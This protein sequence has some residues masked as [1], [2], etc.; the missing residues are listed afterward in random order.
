[1]E[2]NYRKSN[3]N[4]LFSNFVDK[5]LLNVDN[6]QNY[7]PLYSRFFDLNLTNFNSIN[8]NHSQS[9]S[10]IT[11]KKSENKFL[12]K[13]KNE[14]DK[15]F[16]TKPIFFK[17]S[18]L[19]DP[20]KFLIG[21]YHNQKSLL[22]LPKL[23]SS[24]CH[25]KYLDT[26]N[27]SY[28]DGFFT[29]LTSMLLHKHNFSHGVDFY[30]SYLAIKNDYKFNIFDD[31]EYLQDSKYFKANN[32]KE[33]DDITFSLDNEYISDFISTGSNCNRE[34]L[35]LNDLDDDDC[36]LTLSDIS[37]L[38]MLDSIFKPKDDCS[39]N[40]NL[41]YEDN[42]VSNNSKKS[43]STCSSRSS[44]TGSESSRES[45]T[46]EEDSECEESDGDDSDIDSSE[47]SEDSDENSSSGSE[48]SEDEELFINISKFPIQ[49]IALEQCERTLDSLLN[50]ESLNDDELESLVMQIVMTLLTYQK[51]FDLT[52]ND[53]HTN[54]IMYVDTPEKYL[55]YKINNK[56]YRV[57]TY[58]R[59]YKI[60]D[61]GRAIYKYR[62]EIICSDSFHPDGDAAT[63]YNCE[64]YFN[65]KKPLLLPNKSFDLCRLG[66]SIFDFIVDELEENGEIEKLED[67]CSIKST[68]K[69]VILNWCTDDK[70]RNIIY[71]KNGDERYPEFKLYKMIARTVHNHTPEKVLNNSYFDKYIIPFVSKKVHVH[72]IDEYPVLAE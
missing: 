30:G 55:Y 42:N 37:D 49:I 1:M 5:S 31:I 23:H 12:A 22:G 54:N 56:N 24:D 64:P 67:L 10:E 46:D 57:P 50:N 34:K 32:G 9:L 51:V 19:L 18:P 8:L 60:I 53:L 20:I 40:L 61:F 44:D 39:G 15:S 47:N 38:S 4:T 59:I 71:K 48:C 7:V 69:K 36:T 43:N 68:I 17:L 62:G 45:D 28:V 6:P 58:G 16:S 27:A 33:V 21:K 14:D 2:I 13:L 35:T 25:N 41:M 65:E 3:N 63:Q 72:N 29:Y 70:N 26:N 66:C 11:E 52:H